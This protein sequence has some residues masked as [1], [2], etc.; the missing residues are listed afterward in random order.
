[1][2]E[3]AGKTKS[4]NKVGKLKLSSGFCSTET[5]LSDARRLA[6]PGVFGS[7]GSDERRMEALAKSMS[8]LDY[9]PDGDG[10]EADELSL[11]EQ[12]GKA[13]S[14]SQQ[15]AN[16]VSVPGLVK[17][18]DSS[19][20]SAS[21]GRLAIPEFSEKITSP[22]LRQT[23]KLNIPGVFAQ[24]ES[25]PA[26][27]TSKTKSNRDATCA[28]P[29]SACPQAVTL[30]AENADDEASKNCLKTTVGKLGVSQFGEK[31]T[32]STRRPTKK[33]AVPDIFTSAMSRSDSHLGGT[34]PL[35]AR[36]QSQKLVVPS[37]SENLNSSDSSQR[38]LG[39]SV[40]KLQIPDFKGTTVTSVHQQTKKLMVPDIFAGNAA[41]PAAFAKS[42]V[43]V[44]RRTK[45]PSVATSRAGEVQSGSKTLSRLSR[46]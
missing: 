16:R 11:L 28:S 31:V 32:V 13:V 5:L 41:L 10:D 22:G 20:L 26:F 18:A 39:Q 8:A 30:V 45:G 37:F 25:P 46:G 12:T 44:T 4:P 35:S 23:K 14:S 38:E 24:S 43:K 40:G 34:S 33:L 36:R 1:L 15:K 7:P 6:K 17:E 42:N 19:N 2:P 3:Q 29:V 27:A 9:V 21:V